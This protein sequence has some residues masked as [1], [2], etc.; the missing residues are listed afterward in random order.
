MSN[1]LYERMF[2]VVAMVLHRLIDDGE[3]KFPHVLFVKYRGCDSGKFRLPFE[4]LRKNEQPHACA[5]RSV[6]TMFDLGNFRL[7]LRTYFSNRV[8]WEDDSCALV[9]YY[10]LKLMEYES[11]VIDFKLSEDLANMK[12][13]DYKWVPV[14]TPY[15]RDDPEF[16]ESCHFCWEA[17]RHSV[18]S[19]YG[20]K[21]V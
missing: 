10:T 7:K 3:E 21:L 12:I 13:E 16:H 18:A 17:L 4:V 11:E 20:I 15:L 1:A 14:G 9:I 6:N 5:V 2:P 8:D 19:N